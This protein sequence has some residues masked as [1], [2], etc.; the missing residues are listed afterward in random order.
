MIPSEQIEKWAWFYDHGYQNLD[1]FDPEAPR[2][3]AELN[4]QLREAYSLLVPGRSVTFYQF[5]KEATLRMRAFLKTR[6][7]TT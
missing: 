7:P 4:R 3:R 2:A 5:K 6:P 1:P